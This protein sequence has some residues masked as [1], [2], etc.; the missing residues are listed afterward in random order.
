MV[1]VIAVIAVAEKMPLGPNACSLIYATACGQCERSAFAHSWISHLGDKSS[2]GLASKRAKAGRQVKCRTQNV[3]LHNTV[4]ARASSHAVMHADWWRN[5][6]A[7]RIL[8]CLNSGLWPR[9]LDRVT[10][11]Q[12]CRQPRL[13]SSSQ[14]PKALLDKQSLVG[15]MSRRTTDPL[16]KRRSRPGW[17]TRK[18][19][20]CL[21][22]VPPAGKQVVL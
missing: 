4:A 5:T 12:A 20:W 7:A 18:G 21:R 17:S 13:P 3:G 19:W 16:R 14:R 11:G 6:A 8:T 9:E 2:K 15:G 10:V 22:V 1:V